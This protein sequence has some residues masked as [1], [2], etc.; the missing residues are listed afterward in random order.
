VDRAWRLGAGAGAAGGRAGSSGPTRLDAGRR[1]CL[2]RRCE[3]GGDLVGP[4]PVN[5]GFPAS[6]YHLAVDGAGWPLEVRLGPG[7]E[8]ERAHLL[9][10]MTRCVLPAT[11]PPRCGPTVATAAIRCAPHSRSARSRPGSV[12]RPCRRA[13]PSW[14]EEPTGHART[15]TR[16]PQQRSAG[17]PP[18]GRRANQCLA[19]PLPQTH[20]PHRAEQTRLPRLPHPRTHHHPRTGIG[21]SSWHRD[22]SLQ[23]GSAPHPGRRAR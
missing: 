7:N 2:D 3:K 8:N 9:P 14:P 1:R 15:P 16:H 22:V 12:A 19:P 20:D 18:L 13:A 4:S 21:F 6:K 23:L 10:L 5:S 11:S 17:A